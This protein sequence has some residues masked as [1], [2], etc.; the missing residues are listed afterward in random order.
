MGLPCGPTGLCYLYAIVKDLPVALTEGEKGLGHHGAFTQDGRHFLYCNGGGEHA[1]VLD[2]AKQEWVK[3][4]KTGEGS[5]HGA[6]S[7]DGKQ[8]FIVHHSDGVI[9]VI[10]A[11][12]LEAVK[13]IKIGDGDKQAHAAWFT[14]DG[15]FFYAVATGDKALVK[16]DVASLEVA[17]KMPVGEKSFFFAIKDGQS[18]PSTEY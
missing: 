2:V 9:T 11:A 6:L 7:P 13:D 18:F 10:D 17:S 16:V 12:R 4:I 1:S 8:F 15:Q 3:T 14:P 5:G